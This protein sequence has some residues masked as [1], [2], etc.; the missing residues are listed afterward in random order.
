MVFLAG[1]RG[2]HGWRSGS[3]LV[4]QDFSREN[5]QLSKPLPYT[6]ALLWC[7][8][9]CPNILWYT[10]PP[11]W[12]TTC[13]SEESFSTRF[14]AFSWG[15]LTSRTAFPTFYCVF[16]GFLDL[17]D[18]FPHVFTYFRGRKGE[19]EKIRTC[20]IKRSWLSEIMLWLGIGQYERY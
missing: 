18:Y 15:I 14:T 17:A 12:C 6:V 13:T 20:A 16:V 7:S 11:L 19:K 3:L 4:H 8:T 2:I 5:G 9:G 1:D 10:K